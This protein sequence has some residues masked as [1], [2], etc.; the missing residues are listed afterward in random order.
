MLFH[1]TIQ[2][3]YYIIYILYNI[4]NIIYI[5]DRWKNPTNVGLWGYCCRFA[6][7]L[8][9]SSLSL[10]WDDELEASPQHLAQMK[11][12]NA[13][14]PFNSNSPKVS[15]QWSNKKCQHS[16]VGQDRY[17]CMCIGIGSRQTIFASH[18]GPSSNCNSLVA[19]SRI[20]HPSTWGK[21]PKVDVLVSLGDNSA[22]QYEGLQ[23]ESTCPESSERRWH[24]AFNLEHDK[25]W[26]Q[27]WHMSIQTFVTCLFVV[28][29]RHAT[30]SFGHEETDLYKLAKLQKLRFRRR[31]KDCVPVAIARAGQACRTT[32]SIERK[33]PSKAATCYICIDNVVYNLS[34]W[35]DCKLT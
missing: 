17:L 25:T 27:Q 1:E 34:L 4:Y 20:S 35:S 16:K 6:A 24:S 10:P 29:T 12:R 5:Y 9:S 19:C 11:I 22:E 33:V 13:C 7:T 2:T 14:F 30:N 8:L 21:P 26:H 23:D 18:Y 3:I 28:T 15:Q 31:R 32:D